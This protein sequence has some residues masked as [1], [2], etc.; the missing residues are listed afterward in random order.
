[1]LGVL[2]AKFGEDVVEGELQVGGGGDEKRFWCVGCAS[3]GD[4]GEQER[5]EEQTHNHDFNES[6]DCDRIAVRM[7]ETSF[8]TAAMGGIVA[9]IGCSFFA[10]ANPPTE[11]E[12]IEGLIRVVEGLKGAKFIRNGSEYDSGSAAKFLRRKWGTQAKEIVTAR[13][14]IEKAASNSSTSGKPYL[15]RLKEGKTVKFG[16]YLMGEL[17]RLETDP[18]VGS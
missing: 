5:D 18:A 6:R 1:M 16:E 15:I 13:D 4:G 14:F 3:G 2:R 12:K 9:L 8:R 10:I 7:K 17:K 11:K